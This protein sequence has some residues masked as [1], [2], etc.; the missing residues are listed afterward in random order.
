ML[1]VES[2][3]RAASH[4][5]SSERVTAVAPLSVTWFASSSVPSMRVKAGVYSFSPSSA[6]EISFTSEVRCF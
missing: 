3:A 5:S 6:A 1:V 4:I 2:D